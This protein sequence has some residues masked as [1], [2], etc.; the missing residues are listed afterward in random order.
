MPATAAVPP[1]RVV[2]SHDEILRRCHELARQIAAFDAPPCLVVVVEG[3]RPFA[4]VLQR[5]LPGDLPL[6]EVRAKSYV[7]TQSSGQITLTGVQAVP[8][9]GRDVLLLEDIVD[10]G[11]TVAAL[12]R[13]FLDSDAKSCSVATLLSKPSRRVVEVPLAHVGFVIPDEFVIGFGMDVDGRFRELRDVV[14]YDA[15]IEQAHAAAQSAA[16]SAAR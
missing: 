14:V 3:A 13:F 9:R 12:R 1:F 2:F 16:K 15:Q 10:T 7:G 8:C 11:R 4:R 6:H 5:L